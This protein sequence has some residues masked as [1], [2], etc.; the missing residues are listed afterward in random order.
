MTN[1]NH[2][3]WQHIKRARRKAHFRKKMA[4]A[5]ELTAKRTE[6][7]RH[8]FLHDEFD[9]LGIYNP[10]W[11][12]TRAFILKRDHDECQSCGSR[13]CGRRFPLHVHHIVPRRYPGGT[14]RYNNLVALCPRCHKEVDLAIWELVEC[15]RA[16]HAF[17]TA[18]LQ[19]QCRAIL[20]RVAGR[21]RSDHLATLQHLCLLTHAPPRTQTLA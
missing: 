9:W 1:P 17:T 19:R 3:R 11:A 18:E 20:L 7:D 13:A 15:R 4:S 21:H 8:G 10:R 16:T 14:E 2:R 12:R 6:L 5:R